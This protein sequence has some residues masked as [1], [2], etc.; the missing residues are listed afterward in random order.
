MQT[1]KTFL[2]V[3]LGTPDAMSAWNALAPEVRAERQAAGMRAWQAWAERHAAIIV[4][5]GA[6]L[7]RTKSISPTGIADVRNNLAAYVI[8]QAGS[9]EEAAR[10]FVHH[11][12]FTLF[13]GTAVEVMEC[14]P[15]PTM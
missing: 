6:P 8:L 2:A 10:L 15:M 1:M 3:Y 7:G 5:H 9:H 4:D 12:H 11:P 14:L 13:P